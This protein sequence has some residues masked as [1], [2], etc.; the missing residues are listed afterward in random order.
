VFE[1]ETA[2]DGVEGGENP[3]VPGPEDE[4]DE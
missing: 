1:P 3:P 4:I 2:V